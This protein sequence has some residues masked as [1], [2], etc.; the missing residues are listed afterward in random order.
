M[1][2]QQQ[3]DLQTVKIMRVHSER[4]KSS[5]NDDAQITV[6]LKLQEKIREDEVEI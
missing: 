4:D 1:L 2:R 6:K 3:I 5:L